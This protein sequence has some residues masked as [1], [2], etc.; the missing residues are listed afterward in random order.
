MGRIK[1]KTRNI[2]IR[3]IYIGLNI[4]HDYSFF[5]LSL[6][7]V[8]AFC[9]WFGYFFFCFDSNLWCSD[10]NELLSRACIIVWALESRT[11]NNEF[12]WYVYA[13]TLGIN[14]KGIYY[15]ISGLEFSFIIYHKEIIQWTSLV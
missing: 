14:T 2:Y 15:T 12:I 10:T 6:F 9:K 3:C 1:C 5:S 11:G 4:N 13:I 7:L 8:Y